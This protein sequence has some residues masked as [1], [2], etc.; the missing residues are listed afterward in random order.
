MTT[1]RVEIEFSTTGV[2]ETKA[3]ID[4]LQRDTEDKVQKTVDLL[5]AVQL[6]I[7]ALQ[8]AA[9]GLY[10]ALIGS[11][12][13]LNAELLKSQTNIASNL[14][15]FREGTEIVDI[16]DKIT[17]S[18]E[19]L[20]DSL[21]QIEI[22]TKDL[23][24]VTTQQ[25]NGVF[26]VLLQNSA[27]FIGQSKEFSDPIEAATASTKNW[28]AALGTLGLPLEQANQEIGSI[29]RGDV[30][31]PDSI[32]AK[33][34]QISREQYDQWKANGELID[35]LNDKL[36]VF[37]AGNALAANSVAGI[38]SNIQ[39]LVED[40][41]T[42]LGEPL[43]DPVVQGLR[44]VYK[45]MEDNLGLFEE[46]AEVNIQQVLDIIDTLRSTVS[47]LAKEFNFNPEGFIKD[48]SE[49]FT[50]L[51]SLI[52]E[53]IKLGGNFLSLF[54][55]Q[56]QTGLANTVEIVSF[57]IEGLTKLATVLSDM[58]GAVAGFLDMI[59]NLDF[60]LD[61]KGAQ[62]QVAGLTGALDD[63]I[64]AV[65]SYSNITDVLIS[66]SEKMASSTG[67]SKDALEGQIE[68]LEQ[69][70]KELQE[71]KTFRDQDEESILRQVDS[72]NE[73]ITALEGMQTA[74]S[75]LEFQ[76]KSLDEL[77]SAYEVMAGKAQAALDAIENEGNGN[78]QMFSD[79]VGTLTELTEKQVKYGQI[80]VDVARERL[81][82]VANN[83]KVELGLR[84]AALETL[85]A[86]EEDF[87]QFKISQ[88]DSIKAKNE[89][90]AY[91]GE[92]SQ[93]E[94]LERTLELEQGV[95]EDRLNL[96][97]TQIERYRELGLS[98]ER[99]EQERI[100]IV[101]EAA[102]KEREIRESIYDDAQKIADRAYDEALRA[103][104]K[105]EADRIAQ[106]TQARVNQVTSEEEYQKQLTEI[107]KARLE[108]ELQAEQANIAKLTELATQAPG[109][110][111]QIEAQRAVDDAKAKSAQIEQELLELQ[112]DK[113][114][115]A[116]AA[117]LESID[118]RADKI[119][120]KY[121]EEEDSLKALGLSQEEYNSRVAQLNVDRIREQLD[122]ELKAQEEI[123][124]GEALD[125]SKA[126]AK[127]LTLE[128][129]DA[130]IE[131]EEAVQDELQ[132]QVDLLDEKIDRKREYADI[133]QL[134]SEL[135][136]AKAVEKGVISKEEAEIK[137]LKITRDRVDK[138][139]KILRELEEAGTL[140]TEDDRLANEQQVLQAK[141]QISEIN[142]S[143]ADSEQELIDQQAERQQEQ[144]KS[145][146][147]QEGINATYSLGVT[148]HL[149][150]EAEKIAAT[151]DRLQRELILA[152]QRDDVE[153]AA[154][155]E[156]ELAK[157]INEEK[158]QQLETQ[159]K[160]VEE[161]FNKAIT[162]S[163]KELNLMKQKSELLDFQSQSLDREAGL[164]Q[165]LFS[166]AQAQV[167]ALEAGV[168]NE[169]SVV[170]QA[171][172]ARSR[173]AQ[174]EKLSGE[175]REKVALE[176]KALKAQLNALGKE[177][178]KS[179][180]ELLEQRQ[181]LQLE[182]LEAKRQEIELSDQL[183]KLELASQAEANKLAVLKAD[184]KANELDIETDI[185]N[186]K[187]AQLRAEAELTKDAEARARLLEAANKTEQS[188]DATRQ[189][190]DLQRQANQEQMA[191]QDVLL[192]N[193]DKL[194]EINKQTSLDQL[195]TQEKILRSQQAYEAT[196]KGLKIDVD[197]SDLRKVKKEAKEIK[198]E[199]NDSLN[200][201]GTP[202][203]TEI[204]VNVA[205]A[206]LTFKVDTNKLR[207]SM[208][209]LEDSLGSAKTATHLL[210]RTLSTNSS[211]LEGLSRALSKVNF[212]SGGTS[213]T[214][215]TFSA[216]VS[217][218]IVVNVPGGAPKPEVSVETLQDER[219]KTCQ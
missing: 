46:L 59:P 96:I 154:Q 148:A 25:V 81:E 36:E 150:G 140:T 217:N 87:L 184:I 111:A 193:Q 43:L 122:A 11:N 141:I 208:V 181:V 216:N 196:M 128:L 15:L 159:K 107:T 143:I 164:R 129:I 177:G 69:Q 7:G 189:T 45:L 126:R 173:L 4:Q 178:G 5:D 71:L 166:V 76:T 211:K 218:N 210:D 113:V 201:S 47:Q 147:L 155:I 152:K 92:I 205:P 207:E 14:R 133:D 202:I 41:A 48:G 101:Q 10:S 117:E 105:Y 38:S 30:N 130:E 197:T 62:R 156:L 53:L 74:S 23:V 6:G 125:A 209:S 40:M 75:D 98:T 116:E 31:N 194:R 204:P 167:G 26:Q 124:S 185:L 3:K 52:D 214:G 78:T 9:S 174:I 153:E 90:L 99:L 50:G 37:A 16:T 206:N 106:I 65:G 137:K 195:D 162:A 176:E 109:V 110:E 160:I 131:A 56:F 89:E 102:D 179:E 118:K 88:I 183:A 55:E 144:E 119:S 42:R 61:L 142:Q 161:G 135:D 18:Q 19:L 145:K 103:T 73:A 108:A 213:T 186:T 21:K 97:D 51:L 64:E 114:R 83:T 35:K 2:P 187:A 136:L 93:R 192:E 134:K 57:A 80:S 28:A 100:D 8:G 95:T 29:L 68:Q 58:T 169:L 115:E 44:D 72:I 24:G 34:L 165:S 127:E 123:K 1:E 85:T 54:G 17:A 63:S 203:K 91:T 22:D 39:S 86:I 49:I 200:V 67:V 132:A 151:Q 215:G 170:N 175:E 79:A 219:A 188:A 182:Q 190:A 94:N 121:K 191:A 70:K 77:G 171:I 212:G 84:T 82:A 120:E 32:I 13:A 172:Q 112:L 168:S 163:E 33:T 20:R 139:L 66:Q 198:K 180:K 158:E 157:V 149:Q 27:Q 12:E 60:K 199:L 138:E 104:E 146:S